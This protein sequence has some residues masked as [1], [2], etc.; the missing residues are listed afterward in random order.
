MV[1]CHLVGGLPPAGASVGV[2]GGHA[3]H[4]VGGIAGAIRSCA[5]VLLTTDPAASA[6]AVQGAPSFLMACLPDTIARTEL[7]VGVTELAPGSTTPLTVRAEVGNQAFVLVLGTGFAWLPVPDVL[8]ELLVGGD[9]G[10]LTGGLI[11][12]PVTIPI[13]IPLAP[14]LVG[15]QGTLQSVLVGSSL[16][17]SAATA[18]GFTIR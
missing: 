8:G 13:V 14:A 15:L 6:F 5:T 18:A 1:D 3:V 9:V 7:P 4:D 16:A 10:I 2:I 11:T 17:L 12:G